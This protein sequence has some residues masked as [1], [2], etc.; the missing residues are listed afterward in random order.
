MAIDESTNEIE[1]SILTADEVHDCETL[2]EPLSQIENDIE[3]VTGDGAYDTHDSYA[4]AIDK[5]AKPCFPP[6]K[7]ATRSNPKDEAYRLRNH[8]V[9]QVGYHDLAYWKK[10]HNY[11]RRSLA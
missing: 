2:P 5:N 8:A 7:N 4:A 6:R 11:H 3:Q 9:S 1:A 10:K